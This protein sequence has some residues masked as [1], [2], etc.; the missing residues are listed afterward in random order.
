MRVA[1]CDRGPGQ[2]GRREHDRDVDHA[3]GRAEGKEPREDGP[4]R[5]STHYGFVPSFVQEASVQEA[6]V[7]DAFVQE[8]SVQEAFVQ[9]ASVQDASVQEASVQDAFVHDA[10]GCDGGLPGGRIEDRLPAARR[11]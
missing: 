11:S 5:L 2:A 1:L 7:H 3:A 8:A 9:E 4:A 10:S 6:S